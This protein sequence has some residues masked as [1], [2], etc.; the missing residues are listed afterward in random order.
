MIKRYGILGGT[1]DPIHLGHIEL[2]R[3]VKTQI[4]LDKIILVP[5]STPPHRGSPSADSVTRLQMCQ[6]ATEDLDFIEVSDT[7]IMRPNKS[8]AIDTILEL[9]KEYPNIHFFYIIGVDAALEILT[10][11]SPQKILQECDLVISTRPEYSM[12]KFKDLIKNS[13]LKNFSTK[14]S[15][16]E[17]LTPKIS[18]TKIRENIINNIDIFSELNSSVH[19]YIKDKG[20][21]LT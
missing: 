10:W 17:L 21:Y 5:N 1:F 9:K 3:Q 13:F 2:A 14:I 12:T 8:Y 15:I 11:N 7:E 19:K 6:L 18:A 4:K 20:I 16:L